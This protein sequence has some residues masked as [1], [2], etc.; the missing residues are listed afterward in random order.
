MEESKLSKWSTKRKKGLKQHRET[1]I[2]TKRIEPQKSIRKYQMVK[3]HV[4]WIPKKGVK[5]DLSEK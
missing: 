3:T 2:A 5:K 1:T 4:K